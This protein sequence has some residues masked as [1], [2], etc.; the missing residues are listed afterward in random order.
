M[1]KL[2]RKLLN[3]EAS[4]AEI[5]FNAAKNGPR[6][7]CFPPMAGRVWASHETDRAALRVLVR[8]AMN[9]EDEAEEALVTAAQHLTND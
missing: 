8:A 2:S 6:H 7:H 5:G 1:K 4:L 9:V 3:R